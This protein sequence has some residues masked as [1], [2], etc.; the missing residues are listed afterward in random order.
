MR[1]VDVGLAA[2]SASVAYVCRRY[3]RTLREPLD[4]KRTAG[5]LVGDGRG[6]GRL[7]LCLWRDCWRL[8]VNARQVLWRSGCALV[9]AGTLLGAVYAQRP[10]REYPSVEY[11]EGR[12]LPRYSRRPAEWSCVRL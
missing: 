4:P 1:P 11:G 6:H 9:L 10:F 3:P 5:W 8:Q 12:P 7:S 2:A